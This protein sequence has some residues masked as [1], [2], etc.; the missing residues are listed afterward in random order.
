MPTNETDV[1]PLVAASY[2][3]LADGLE[4]LP[5]SAWDTPSMCEGWRV[6]EVVAHLTMPVRYTEETFMAELRECDFDFTRL[7]NR[8]A[9]RDSALPTGELL[10]QLRDEALHHWTPPGGGSHGALSH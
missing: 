10:G 5:E 6:R 7:S 9:A 2:V 1:R 4:A 3:G 8:V